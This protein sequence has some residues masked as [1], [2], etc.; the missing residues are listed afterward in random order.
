VMPGVVE[1]TPGDRLDAE[2]DP[3]NLY[4]FDLSGRLVAAPAAM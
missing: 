2:V 4:I 3:A 1:Y